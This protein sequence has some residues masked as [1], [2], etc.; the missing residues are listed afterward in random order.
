MQ[1]NKYMEIIYENK[2]WKYIK[3]DWSVYSWNLYYSFFIIAFYCS[4]H[5]NENIISQL[6]K[7]S[8]QPKDAN[9]LHIYYDLEEGKKQKVTLNWYGF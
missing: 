7:D 1:E 5:Y 4:F 8:K 6:S 3:T 9:I 2:T